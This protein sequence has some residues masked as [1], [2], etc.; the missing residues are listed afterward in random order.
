MRKT[1]HERGAVYAEPE[2]IEKVEG[3]RSNGQSKN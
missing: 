2:P 3:I 1:E